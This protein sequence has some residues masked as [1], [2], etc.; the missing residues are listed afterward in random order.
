MSLC[1][2]ME[3]LG[4]TLTS[5]LWLE[6]GLW[7]KREWMCLEQYKMRSSKLSSNFS[8]IF[9]VSQGTTFHAFIWKQ[10]KIYI[11]IWKVVLS[12]C[13]ALPLFLFNSKAL[14]KIFGYIGPCLFKIYPEFWLLT[15]I[16][17]FYTMRYFLETKLNSPSSSS[18]STQLS[19]I[20]SA[21]FRNAIMRCAASGL[22]WITEITS[23]RL[24]E[25]YS[26]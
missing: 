10:T 8:Y 25:D 1:R 4:I 20:Q 7:Y 19:Y 15:L 26:L 18:I 6:I 9:W 3:K 17:F 5:S 16:Q 21:L 22:F 13:H 2:S 14:D 11:K 24:S 12:M 23:F